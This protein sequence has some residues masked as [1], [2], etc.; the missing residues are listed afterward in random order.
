MKV[1]LLLISTFYPGSCG[2]ERLSRPTVDTQTQTDPTVGQ[3]IL[4]NVLFDKGGGF[5][6]RLTRL[7]APTPSATRGFTQRALPNNIQDYLGRV[8]GQGV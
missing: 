1:Q 4:N 2:L 6:I 5:T 8:I 3:F 7:G